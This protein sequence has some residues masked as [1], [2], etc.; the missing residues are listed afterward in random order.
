MSILALELS[1]PL[2]SIAFRH[3]DGTSVVRQFPADRKDSGFFF[4][5]LGDLRRDCGLPDVIAVGLGPGSYAGI[6]IAIATALGLR[7]A[8]GARLVG[9]PSICAMDSAEY[10]VVGDAR[11]SSYFFAHVRDG[12]CMEGPVLMSE[13]ELRSKLGEQTNLPRLAAQ[14]LPQFAEVTVAHPSASILARLA[15]NRGT[16]EPLEPIYLR[17]PYITTPK[18]TPWNR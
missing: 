3:P 4:Q 13:T 18:A 14:S 6:R 5:N 2:G 15:E 8:A 11:R 9:W 10:F 7:A 17:E 1:S 16:E 12:D